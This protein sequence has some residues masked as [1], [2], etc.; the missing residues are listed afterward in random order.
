MKERGVGTVTDTTLKWYRNAD[1]LA[2]NETPLAARRYDYA[3]GEY[4]QAYV[5]LR[6]KRWVAQ[7]EHYLP[8]YG[9]RATTLRGESARTCLAAIHAN[10]P[11]IIWEIWERNE[12]I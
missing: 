3:G 11:E 7:L 9:Y 6:N 4:M 10:Q 5:C 2:G 8:G 1:Y 12:T